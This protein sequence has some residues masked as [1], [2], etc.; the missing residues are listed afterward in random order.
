MTILTPRADPITSFRGSYG[1]LS[2]FFYSTVVIHGWAFVTSEHAYQAWKMTNEED[3]RLVQEQD[4]PALAKRVARRNIIREDWDRI[5][6]DVMLQV[7][8]A[9]FQNPDLIL[10]LLD[11]G[12]RTLVE[13]NTW[14]DRFWGVCDGVGQNRLGMCLMQVRSELRAKT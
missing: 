14:G 1:F 9:K 12:D 10:K 13:G 4:T 8:R 5:K 11:T 3:A 6:I 2:N 7:L